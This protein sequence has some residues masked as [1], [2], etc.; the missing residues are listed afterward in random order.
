VVLR[1][2]G[3]CT[4]DPD[5][6]GRERSTARA[7]AFTHIADGEVLPFIDVD[8]DRIRDVIRP[9]V[10]V[11]SAAEAGMLLGRAM[12]RVIAHELLHVLTGSTAHGRRGVCRKALS[13]FELVEDELELAPEDLER[14]PSVQH[15]LAGPPQP[16][17]PASI[18]LASGSHSA[19]AAEDG[20]HIVHP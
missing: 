1:F 2:H 16:S 13:G 6:P 11:R 8:C 9:E 10:K 20:E 17:A 18:P 3:Q 14:L 5:P 12:G 19:F 15:E 7:L 4:P